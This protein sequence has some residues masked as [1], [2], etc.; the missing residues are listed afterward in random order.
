MHHLANEISDLMKQIGIPAHIKGYYYIRESILMNIEKQEYISMTK[1]L[2]PQI[3]QK[4]TT[5]PQ[6]VERAIRHAIETTWKRGNIA[7]LQEIFGCTIDSKKGKPTNS[8]FIAMISDNM[9]LQLKNKLH[10]NNDAFYYH[11]YCEDNTYGIMGYNEKTRPLL[12]NKQ[13]AEQF[14]NFIN[15]VGDLSPEH[16]NDVFE[17]FVIDNI[18]YLK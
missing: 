1:E 12:K 11:V 9:R 8:E 6:R 18:F 10:N 4:F 14:V 16:L 2:Y 5:T 3:A 15:K 17:D 7:L 13:T